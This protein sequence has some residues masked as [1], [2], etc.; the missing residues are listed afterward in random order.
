MPVYQPSELVLNSWSAP[1][2]TPASSSTSRSGTPMKFAVEMRLPPTGLETHVSV[3]ARSTSG[4]PTRSLKL[5]VSSRPTMPCTRRL[6]SAAESV[7]T[8]KAVSIR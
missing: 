7:G 6:Q 5:S 1:G 2:A 3:T 4:R 8:R